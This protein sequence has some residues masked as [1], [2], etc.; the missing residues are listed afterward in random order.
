MKEVSAGGGRTV[1]FVSHSMESIAKLC[2]SCILMENG[3]VK[4]RGL[5]ETVIKKY[6]AVENFSNDKVNTSKIVIGNIIEIQKITINDLDLGLNSV[7]QGSPMNMGFLINNLTNDKVD[8]YFNIE[9]KTMDG[10]SIGCFGNSFQKKDIVIGESN[11]QVNIEIKET[12]LKQGDYLIS[13]YVQLGHKLRRTNTYLEDYS[14]LK[15]LPAV[16][17]NE[18]WNSYIN[19][20]QHGYNPMLWDNIEV[21]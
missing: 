20:P 8:I 14:V 10:Q 5:T 2:S 13:I 19:Q 6:L 18:N 1:L 16:Y 9:L 11:T 15:V 21:I 3:M 4:E 7:Y 17:N 12:I